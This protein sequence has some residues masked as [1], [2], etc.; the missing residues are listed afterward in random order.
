MSQSGGDCPSAAETAPLRVC[1]WCGVELDQGVA[2]EKLPAAGNPSHGI[3]KSCYRRLDK[4]DSKPASA[5]KGRRPG[6]N[7]GS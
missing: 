6:S 2:P 1:A 4:A 3:C 5:R 7:G